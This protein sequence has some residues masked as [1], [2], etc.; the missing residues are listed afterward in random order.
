M[1]API[2]KVGFGLIA[3]LLA[4][5]AQLTYVQVVRAEQL[6]ADP[7]NFRVSER[8]F[9]RSRGK[10][11]T[12]DGVVL[13]ESIPTDDLL[14]F[15]RVYAHGDTYAHITGYQS[16]LYGST[17]VERVYD[18]A[19]L[20]KTIQITVGN[21]DALFE[22]DPT[23]DV[24]LTVQSAAQEA[25]KNALAGRRGS[26]VVLD[27]QTG[28][29]VAMYS[30][31]SYD[32]NRIASHNDTKA[33]SAFNELVAD[34]TNPMQN[35]STREI[36]PP[37][38]TFKVVT[39][40]IALDKGIVT[41]ET[42]FPKL[43]S[44]RLPLSDRTLS[45]FGG[46]TCGG[47]LREAFR[48]SCNTVFAQ[49]G[50]D[51]G[52]DLATGGERFGL[53]SSGPP[54]DDSPRPV[55]SIGALPGTFKSKQPQFAL[56]AIGQGDTATTPL[57]MALVA[58]AVA[59]GGNMLVP[60]FL[61]RI[62]DPKRPNPSAPSQGSKVWRSVMTPT[63]AAQINEMMQSVVRDGT[64]TAAQIPGIVVAGKTG[65]AQTRK[66]ASPHAW[67][68]G[69]APAAAP[70]YAIAVLVENGGGAGDNATGGRVAAPIAREVLRNIFT[71]NP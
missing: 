56:D 64:G 17:G 40:A 45:N 2:R 1:N 14:K 50:L 15:Q 11:L 42:P 25:A 57:E 10:I 69:F 39:T 67:F 9:A 65:T 36:Y 54:L 26:V 60:H 31:P 71:S 66:G 53:N 29:I 34:D 24:R 47:P 41:P 4:L 68:I 35:K 23:L 13:A 48:Q 16:L 19:L 62:E 58:Q 37:G 32:P 38:S 18:D 51:L 70:R 5:I 59:T 49:M 12:A 21:V 28:G 3:M 6:T 22:R 7:Q 52:E 46:S 43:S 61:A 55:G 27:T 44:L 33:R 20:G 8:D 30:N 63:T